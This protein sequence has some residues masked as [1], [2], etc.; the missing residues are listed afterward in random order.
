[1]NNYRKGLIER[2]SDFIPCVD[3]NVNGTRFGFD[4][5]MIWRNLHENENNTD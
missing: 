1:M 2:S 4:H 3:C 5:A